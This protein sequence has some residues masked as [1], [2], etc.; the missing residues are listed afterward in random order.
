MQ[1]QGSRLVASQSQG[2]GASRSSKRD[3]KTQGIITAQGRGGLSQARGNP[4]AFRPNMALNLD[5]PTSGAISRSARL[6]TTFV[7]PGP[8]PSHRWVS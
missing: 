4:Q 5:P 7:N 3:M 8:V 1:V 6:F 2:M